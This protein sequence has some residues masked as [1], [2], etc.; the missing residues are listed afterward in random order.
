MKK[1]IIKICA[2]FVHSPSLCN[3]CMTYIKG[4]LFNSDNMEHVFGLV[5]HLKLSLEYIDVSGTYPKIE[6]SCTNICVELIGF[7]FGPELLNPWFGPTRLAVFPEFFSWKLRVLCQKVT[8]VTS[9]K[10]KNNGLITSFYIKVTEFLTLPICFIAFLFINFFRLN[11]ISN[12]FKKFHRK[13]FLK[14]F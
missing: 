12:I 13:N 9:K 5:A 3:A 14:N 4:W 11:K 7:K 6:F 8:K 2:I 1:S 10:V